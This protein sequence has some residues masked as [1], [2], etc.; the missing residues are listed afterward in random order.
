MNSSKSTQA[1]FQ[2]ATIKS[3]QSVTLVLFQRNYENPLRENDI[4]RQQCFKVLRIKIKR[5][6]D[7]L[8]YNT[9]RLTVFSGQ[10][11]REI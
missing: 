6:F 3:E 7:S 2:H 9:S 1:R 5:L 11:G 10:F 4:Y 8:R